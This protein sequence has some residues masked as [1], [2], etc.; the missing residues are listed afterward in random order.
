[1]LTKLEL[2]NRLKAMR[3]ENQQLL[4]QNHQLMGQ[5]HQLMGQNQQLMAQNQQLQASLAASQAREQAL[6]RSERAAVDSMR[7]LAW[8]YLEVLGG[9]LVLHDISHASSSD[10]EV[11]DLM[12]GD[13]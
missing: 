1:M 6:I 5:N 2:Q 3:E 10:L 4:L 7:E 8:Q 12:V 13:I 11:A 9:G